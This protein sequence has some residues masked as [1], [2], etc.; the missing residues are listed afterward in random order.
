MQIRECFLAEEQDVNADMNNLND[1]FGSKIAAELLNPSARCTAASPVPKSLADLLDILKQDPPPSFPM[2]RTTCSLLAAYLEKSVEEI[3]INLIQ[4]SRDRF[5]PYLASQKYA[6]NSIR[7]YVNHVRNLL[8]AAQILGWKPGADLPDGWRSVLSLAKR[9]KCLDIAIELATLSKCPD[10][11]RAEDV[12]NWVKRQVQGGVAYRVARGK[13]GRFWS[14]LKDCGFTKEL[15]TFLIQKKRYGVALRDFPPALRTEVEAVLKWKQA[16][17]A[18]DRPKG[19]KHRLVSSRN[20][21]SAISRLFG[22]SVNILGRSVNSLAGL[23]QKEILVEYT[24]WSLNE[25]AAKGVSIQRVFRSLYAVMRQYPAYRSLD[26]TWCGPLIDSI[27]IEQES[28]QMRRKSEKYLEYSALETIPGKIRKERL[29]ASKKTA[30]QVAMLIMQELLVRWLISLPW[31][32]RNLREC[33]VCGPHSNLFRGKI[34]PVI[35][36]DRP[37]WVRER[38][39]KDVNAEF[40]QFQFNRDETKMKN[41]VHAVLPRPLSRA[42]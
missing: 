33:R 23:F 3:T 25:R 4:S 18:P 19:G 36:I 31:R 29:S 37:E 30:K 11:V 39:E 12:E 6:E 34:P 14:L 8:R 10:E 16:K 15:P 41:E 28:E 21:Q 20:L 13:R 27:P 7:T 38:E 26:S 42:E 22:F 24:S 2:L 5:R 17:F 35:P 1:R 40:W 32:Q 9:R